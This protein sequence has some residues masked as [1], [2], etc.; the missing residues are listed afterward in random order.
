MTAD[1][2]SLK[3]ASEKQ[4]RE[5]EQTRLNNESTISDLKTKAANTEHEFQRIQILVEKQRNEIDYINSEQEK[6]KSQTYAD[7]V[8]KFKAYIDDS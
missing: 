7:K 2:D 4:I 5:L 6:F 8:H 3:G 1:I